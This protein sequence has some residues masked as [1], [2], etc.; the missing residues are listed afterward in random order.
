MADANLNIRK[1]DRRERRYERLERATGEST[2]VGALDAAAKFYLSMAGG[3]ADH[4]TGALEELLELADD[5]GAV[6][7]EEIVDVLDSKE[8]PIDYQPAEWE[9]KK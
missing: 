1:T 7:L 2:T 9:I 6:T 8:F 5:Q 3:P 4:Q